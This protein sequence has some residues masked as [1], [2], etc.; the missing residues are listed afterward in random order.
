MVPWDH[1]TSHAWDSQNNRT[2][3]GL[4][5]VQPE[6]KPVIEPAVKPVTPVSPEP[7]LMSDNVATMSLL[8]ATECHL[9]TLQDEDGDTWVFF[10]NF[11]SLFTLHYS[12]FACKGGMFFFLL[13]REVKWLQH[14]SQY[15]KGR[16]M[17]NRGRKEI[18]FLILLTVNH[19]ILMMLVQRIQHWIN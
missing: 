13:G 6:V 1:I 2:C 14:R 11:N 12:T 17:V 15:R 9:A 10:F 3:Y 4:V 7:K 19:T 18:K 8:S 5:P 16:F